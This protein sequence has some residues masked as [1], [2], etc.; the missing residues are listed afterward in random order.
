MALN[1]GYTIGELQGKMSYTELVLW[2]K[3]RNKYGPLSPVRKYDQ[4]G[5]MIASQI[6]RMGGGKSVPNDFLPY[7]ISEEDEEISPDD[8]MVAASA[9]AGVKRGR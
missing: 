9:F 4:M 1:L 6:N 8:F 5:A 2:K 3:Y 7:R